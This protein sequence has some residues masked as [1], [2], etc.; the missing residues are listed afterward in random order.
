MRPAPPTNRAVDMCAS[1]DQAS[2]A[3]GSIASRVSLAATSSITVTAT[4]NAFT[5][6]NPSVI[7]ASAKRSSFSLHS[8]FYA[9]LALNEINLFFPLQGFTGSG[10]TCRPLESCVDNESI[11]H[12]NALC[13]WNTEGYYGCR[14]REGF[15]G[16]GYQCQGNISVL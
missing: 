11:C 7:D 12:A 1:A 2:T 15:R 6:P 5:I 10:T 4:L 16:D 14:C 13:A 3:T 9:V 8:Q